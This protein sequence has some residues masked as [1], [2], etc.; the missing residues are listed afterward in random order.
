MKFCPKCSTEFE[1]DL[2]FCRLD[3]TSLRSKV[4]S[5]LCS[6]CGKKVEEGKTFCRY[7]GAKLEQPKPLK[8]GPAEDAIARPK[9]KP[10]QSIAGA[11]SPIEIAEDCLR[12]GNYKDA[13]SHLESFLKKNPDDQEARL[14]HLF[15]SVKLYNV[16]GYEKQI[17]SIR[18]LPDLTEKEGE[19]AREIFL[20][21]SDEAQKHGKADEARE[22]QRLAT[23]VILGQPLVEPKPEAKTVEQKSLKE[24]VKP[25]PRVVQEPVQ[26]IP[27]RAFPSAHENRPLVQKRMEHRSRTGSRLLISFVLVFG[28]AG[29][30]VV[31]M[32]V[33]YAKN[34]GIAIRDLFTIKS[35]TEH[36]PKTDI[37][38]AAPSSAAQVIG[39]E[40]LGFRVWGTGATDVN[41]R[42]SL[43]SEKIASQLASLRQL[44]QQ[45]VQQKP[46]LMGSV[47]LQLTISPSGMVTKV[48]DFASRIKDKEFKKL[49]IDEAYKWRFPEASSGLTKVNYPLLFVPPGMDLATLIKW[50]Q[51][52]GPKG[53]E[54]AE[55][56][57]SALSKEAVKSTGR[58]SPP[59]PTRPQPPD[60]SSRPPRPGSEGR[61]VNGP[62]EV[63]Y[64]TSVYSEPRED[65]RRVAR[66][67][68]G[69]RIN[70]VGGQG[71]W[72]EV[73][74]KHG[75]P[76][77]FIKK[78]SAMPMGSR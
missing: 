44:Y 24:E 33:Y 51:V 53:P 35:P 6:Q 25:I 30:L 23:R 18:N 41:R 77:G 9:E 39:A 50:E 37:E 3:G 38:V 21:R 7:C 75:N 29:I 34:Q 5:K 42:E 52:A 16:Y 27:S 56:K 48:Q 17:E 1:D 36:K 20:I 65:S 70:V 58:R 12:D 32:L 57:E 2:N 76:P 28:L 72:L 59:D 68:A 10:E 43:I 4:S 15:V 47:T 11:K 74:S 49:V 67:E 13:I 78:E 63:L 14:L 62:Y 40:E 54:P 46:D 22:Y 31:G 69:T 64:P 61:I 45:E 73:R 8:P 60:V 71:D 66:V 26:T 19:I 55:L